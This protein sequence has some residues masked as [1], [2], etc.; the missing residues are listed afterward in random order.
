MKKP[1][2]KGCIPMEDVCMKHCQPLICRHGCE[3]VLPHKCEEYEKNI[4]VLKESR[5]DT[6]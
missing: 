4:Q 3:E 6:S 2:K 5:N 1:N